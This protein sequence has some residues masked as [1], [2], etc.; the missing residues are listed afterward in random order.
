MSQ[1]RLRA[2]S[3][4]RILTVCSFAGILEWILGK[5]DGIWMSFLTRSVLENANRYNMD[6][7]A[8]RENTKDVKFVW[9]NVVFQM[10]GPN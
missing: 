9:K 10:C 3:G 4:W 1:R 5:R 2:H 6:S 8:S 7:L